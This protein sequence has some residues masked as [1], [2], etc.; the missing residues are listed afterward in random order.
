MGAAGEEGPGPGTAFSTRP[1]AT[2]GEPASAILPFCFETIPGKT[3]IKNHGSLE[4][5][6]LSS[7]Y[8]FFRRLRCETFVSKFPEGLFHSMCEE[9]SRGLMTVLAHRR[10]TAAT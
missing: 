1:A 6:L 2:E 10:D 9:R 8:C 4:D 7:R 5:E 3:T